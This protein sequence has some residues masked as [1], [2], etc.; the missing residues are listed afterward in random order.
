MSNGNLRIINSFPSLCHQQRFINGIRLLAIGEMFPEPKH[1]YFNRNNK[2][3]TVLPADFPMSN[4]PNWTFSKLSPPIDIYL[5]IYPIYWFIYPI[6]SSI[7][8]PRLHIMMYSKA[9]RSYLDLLEC[10]A[11]LRTSRSQPSM[12][13]DFRNLYVCLINVEIMKYV[14]IYIYLLIYVYVY[15]Y[16]YNVYIYMYVDVIR[17]MCI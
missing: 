3:F 9:V 2:G 6:H 15:L 12:S 8:H 17:Y 14:Y 13:V 7:W 11:S 4:S 10:S 16:M 5:P 1:V